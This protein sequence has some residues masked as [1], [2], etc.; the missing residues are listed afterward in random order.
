MITISNLQK[1]FGREKALCGCTMELAPG[2]FGLLG[3][4]GAGKTT[5]M[6]TLLGLY[7][8]DGGTVSLHG[9]DVT[10]TKKLAA[11]SGYLPQ[12]FGGFGT[13][14][15]SD[16]LRYLAG[17]KKIA[18]PEEEIE[19]ALRLTNLADRKNDKIKTLSGGMVRRLGIAQAILGK[20]E[21]MIFDEPTTGLDPEER[22][23]FRNLV[24]QLPRD[25]VIIISTHIVD[26]VA[27]ICDQ[28]AVMRA[29]A[30]VLQSEP[31]HLARLAE[32]HVFSIPHEMPIPEDSV[33]SSSSI[34]SKKNRVIS[35]DPITDGTEETPTLEDGYL[36]VLHNMG[37]T[38]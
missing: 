33:L 7:R 37:E 36:Y 20:P 3:P 30:C 14:R 6:R 8:S 19:D 13:M 34:Y 4:N 25:R 21:V 18:H 9:T 15:V 27:M 26:D 1:N 23:R 31:E 32:H 12:A 38:A 10:N 17:L 29:G 16:F 2:I 35:K 28:V 5:L 24:L 11:I 22:I